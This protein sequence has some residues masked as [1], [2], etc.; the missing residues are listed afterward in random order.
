M[1]NQP[2]MWASWGKLLPS[3]F[4]CNH[5]QQSRLRTR[6]ISPTSTSF[7]KR[8]DTPFGSKAHKLA[9]PART[10]SRY[11]SRRDSC[12]NSSNLSFD[13]CPYDLKA[14]VS[15]RALAPN[16]KLHHPDGLV[17]PATRRTYVGTTCAGKLST[18]GGGKPTRR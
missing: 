8:D 10:Q 4:A 17:S 2:P 7:R 5:P 3:Q 18:C 15:Q 14:G 13:Y 12:P 9:F 1:A 16:R 11:K 6:W